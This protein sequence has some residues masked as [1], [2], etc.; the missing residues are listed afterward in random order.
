MNARL[1]ILAFLAGRAPGAYTEKAILQRVNASGLL[2]THVPSIERELSELS[3]DRMGGLVNCDIDKIT[4]VAFWYATDAGINRWE[5]D[6]R[7]HVA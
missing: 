3:S 1:V 2:D 6:G 5:R 4:K 7:P